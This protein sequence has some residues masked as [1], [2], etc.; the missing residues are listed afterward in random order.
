MGNMRNVKMNWDSPKTNYQEFSAQQYISSCVWRATLHC[1]VYGNRVFGN[2]SDGYYYEGM[3]HGTACQNTVVTVRKDKN[4][5]L[6]VTGQ[7]VPK[8]SL[9]IYA[10]EPTFNWGT[11][12]TSAPS[13]PKNSEIGSIYSEA[14]WSSKDIN[15]TG[16][17][18]HIGYVAS[19]EEFDGGSNVS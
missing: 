7:E 8:G 19:W 16:D 5:K 6:T 10:D 4:G 11:R 13:S 2:A 9:V 17:Y 15:G 18:K 1:G 14:L 12:E 3:P